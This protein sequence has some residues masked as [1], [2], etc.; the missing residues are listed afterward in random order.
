MITEDMVRSGIREHL[1]TFIS[2]SSVLLFRVR[3]PASRVRDF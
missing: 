3:Q 1:I 2:E